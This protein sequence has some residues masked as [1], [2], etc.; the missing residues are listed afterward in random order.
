MKLSIDSFIKLPYNYYSK[1]KC[2]ALLFYTRGYRW[3]LGNI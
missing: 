1:V 3:S 2:Y